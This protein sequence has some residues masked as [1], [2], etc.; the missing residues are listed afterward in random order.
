M[1]T[2]FSLQLHNDRTQADYGIKY[3]AVPA[4]DGTYKENSNSIV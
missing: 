4:T 2:Y 1:L 3:E